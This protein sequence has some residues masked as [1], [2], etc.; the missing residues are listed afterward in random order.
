M[1]LKTVELKPFRNIYLSFAA[2]CTAMSGTAILFYLLGASLPGRTN[3]PFRSK[4][5]L[6][7]LVVLAA[8]GFY[9]YNQ[10]QR[11]KLTGISDFEKK[12]EYYLVCY[13]YRFW[14][15]VLS[16]FVSGILLLFTRLP[17]VLLF[18]GIDLLSMLLNYP[19]PATIRRDL[20]E[21]DILVH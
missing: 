7:T 21:E 12:K 19:T 6:L 3:L 1:D 2:L 20:N 11:K 9:F 5:I 8:L 16:C 10:R 4:D 13:R 17:L 18:C 15:H 14:L